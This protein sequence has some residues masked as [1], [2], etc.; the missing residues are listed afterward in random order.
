MPLF[1]TL[2]CGAG[3]LAQ[4]VRSS[5]EGRLIV[6]ALKLLARHSWHHFVCTLTRVR[7]F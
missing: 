4:E 1:W 6:G 2:L 3:A 5:V 7:V